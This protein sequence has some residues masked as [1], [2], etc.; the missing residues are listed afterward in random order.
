MI[1][2][3][4]HGAIHE[5]RLAR[6]PANAFDLNLILAL[7]E[8][9][10]A[11]PTEGKRVAVI[12][13]SPGMFSGGLDIGALLALGREDVWR[14]VRAFFELQYVVAASPIPTIMAITGHSAG[15]GTELVLYSDYRVMANGMYRIGINEV[16]V[17][18]CPGRA[19]YGALRRLVGAG[20]ADR[21]LATGDMISA[22]QALAAGLVDELA[23]VDDVINKAVQYGE[24]LAS[25]PIKA[26]RTTRQLAR[27]DLLKSLEGGV[28]KDAC[29]ELVESIMTPEAQSALRARQ[30]QMKQKKVATLTP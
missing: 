25:L 29:E 16:K 1:N 8:R 20:Y 30:E 5:I 3:F 4:S 9:L 13:G 19:T 2:E 18:L 17:G 28:R 15:G 21:L 27:E 26:Y 7:T 22:E 6:P 12:S 23:E 10:K 11:I 14:F 24:G